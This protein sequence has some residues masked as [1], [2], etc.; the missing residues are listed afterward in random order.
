MAII[1]LKPLLTSGITPPAGS[2]PLHHRLPEP[3]YIRSKAVSAKV[4]G[5]K[6]RLDVLAAV[7]TVLALQMGGD[8][9]SAGVEAH[10][11]G[12]PIIREVDRAGRQYRLGEDLLV[13]ERIKAYNG[14]CRRGRPDP[15][16]LDDEL[17]EIFQPFGRIVSACL[18]RDH[19]G[20][21][22]GFGFVEIETDEPADVISAVD[23]TNIKGREIV[24]RLIQHSP[25]GNA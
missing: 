2:N 10:R 18:V 13:R 21:C 11:T 3:R 5:N 1:A 9:R 4:F 12:R 16:L 8:G 6:H 14:S 17:R 15:S 7:A 24:V 22:L 23:G 20:E 19:N 25:F